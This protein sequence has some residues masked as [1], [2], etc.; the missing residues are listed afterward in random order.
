MKDITIYHNP[1]CGTS[2][3]VLGLIRGAG[4]E[5]QVIEYLKTPP[6]RATLESL[7]AQMNIRPRDLLREKGTPYAELGLGEDRWSD[8]ELIDQMLAHPILINR[9]I[10]VTPRGTKLCRP[11]ET[12]KELLP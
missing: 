7:I 10:V 8:A 11:S 1:A 4:I 2:R 12:V 6:D 3:N 9:P 5:P